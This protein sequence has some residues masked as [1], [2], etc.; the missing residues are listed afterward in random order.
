MSPEGHIN[1]NGVEGN[2]SFDRVYFHYPSRTD[3]PVS[4]N[5]LVLR[6]IVIYLHS[7]LKV[8]KGI[9]MHIKCG[10]TVA[11]VGSSGNGKS[12]CI[13]LLQRFYDPIQGSITI[14]GHDIKQFNLSCLR[15]TMATVGQ[16]PVLFATTIEENIRYGKPDATFKEIQ[17]AAKSAGAHDFISKLQDVYLILSKPMENNLYVCI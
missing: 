15:S 2:V 14:D 8:L 1:N 13:Q 3:V 7:M 9:S 12:T 4:R 17:E 10:E 5:R 11:L 16:E 6:S